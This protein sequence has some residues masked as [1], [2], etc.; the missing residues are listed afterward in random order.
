MVVIDDDHEDFFA[1]RRA[2]SEHDPE[3]EM[4]HLS[5]GALAMETLLAVHSYAELPDIVLLD[6]NMPRVDGYETLAAL[7][8]SDLTRHLP[9]IMFSTSDSGSEILKS[10]AAGA[11]AHMVKPSSMQELHAFARAISIFWLE[12]AAIP[13]Q[14]DDL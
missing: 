4:I 3:I 14:A 1:V 5:D 6:I 7:R 10:Y 8:S 13:S 9:V 2:F 11:N 12:S